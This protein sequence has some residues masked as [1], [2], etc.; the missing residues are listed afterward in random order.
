MKH[1]SGVDKLGSWPRSA[2]NI[3]ITYSKIMLYFNTGHPV[4]LLKPEGLLHIL[5][6]EGKGCVSGFS[7]KTLSLLLGQCKMLDPPDQLDF[8]LQIV[9]A[10]RLF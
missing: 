10:I 3:F 2:K 4:G 8:K 6:L 7:L 9:N 5:G 1:Y